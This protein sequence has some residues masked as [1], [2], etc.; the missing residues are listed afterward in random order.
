ML[1]FFLFER[2]IL[3][4][5]FLKDFWMLFIVIGGMGVFFNGVY[6]K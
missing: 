6:L 3:F 2:C 5:I 4:D 1:S